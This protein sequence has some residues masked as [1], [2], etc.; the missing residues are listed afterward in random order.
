[1]KIC[2]A[3][4]LIFFGASCV[5]NTW[6]HESRPLYIEITEIQPHVYQVRWKVPSSVAA[7][8]TPRIQMP[9]GCQ[10]VRRS[11]LTY[12]GS[13]L[14]GKDIFTCGHDIHDA[15]LSILYPGPNPALST[16]IRYSS[17]SGQKL[18]AL[19]DP[20]QAEW[21][22][23]NQNNILGMI[24]EYIRIGIKHI[25]SGADHLLFVL[26]L[27]LIVSD[28]WVLLKTVSAFTVAHSITLAVA[29]LGHVSMSTPLLD[30]LIAL[31]I[32]F[33]GP[34]IV[35]V[36][37]G[38]TSFTIRHPWIVAFAFGLLHGFGFATG[39]TTLGLSHAEI[40]PALLFFNIGV[41]I[42]QLGFIFF[43]LALER[44]FRLMEI[45]WP[46]P[47]RKLPTYTVGALGACWSIRCMAVLFGGAL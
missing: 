10:D 24:Q 46:A 47:L 21:H 36:H 23:P 40:F 3:I 31:S 13:A 27:L 1:M 45:T 5:S 26:G 28:R 17:L 32:F 39:L 19:L 29:T 15:A 30:T 41:E 2:P 22:I 20:Q 37:R 12:G 14:E 4:A 6:A 42:G 35:R 16:M 7:F 38:G 11:N 9:E 25:L 18:S 33:L 34:E 43:I 8:A 44:A